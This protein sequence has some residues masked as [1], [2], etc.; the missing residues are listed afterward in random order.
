[1]IQPGG[2]FPG[3]VPLDPFGDGTVSQA[4]LNYIAPGR[5]GF[6]IGGVA[7]EDLALYLLGQSVFS[8]STQGVLPFGLPAGKP[9]I[10]FGFED[11]LEQQTNY[12][13]PLELGA[14]GVFESGNFSEFAGEYNVQEGNL[15]LDVPVLKN[16]IVDD[17]SLNAAG[18]ITSYST[19]GLV[20]TWKLGATSQINDDIKLR[21]TLSSDIRAPGV[22]ELFSPILV[23]TQTTSYPNG[24]PTFNIHELQAGNP[25]L[26]P[27]QA[28][29]VSGG[30]VLTPHWI[31]NL[32]M[33]FDWYSITLHGGIFS[34][35]SSQIIG[36]CTSGNKTFCQFVFF[37]QGFPG[38]SSTPVA[39]EIDANGNSPAAL[40]GKL[41][42]SADREGAF[43]AYYQGPVNANAKPTRVWIS[44]WTISMSCS[45]A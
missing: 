16:N 2:L 36:Q 30:V 27:E 43:N 33:S 26:Q 5:T 44:R 24:G 12:R 31:E 9:A 15:E 3:C 14:S 17:L 42:F 19:S 34:P 23:S 28:E 45:P 1:M 25:L 41:T 29:T 13:D 8:V 22:G 21:T 6:G 35:S 37:G 20:E 39:S 18:R 40:I 38:N 32:S 4:A 7:S 10:E 11:R